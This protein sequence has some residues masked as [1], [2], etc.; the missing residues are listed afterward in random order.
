MLPTSSTWSRWRTRARCPPAFTS[1]AARTDH[2]PSTSCLPLEVRRERRCGDRPLPA[3][4]VMTNFDESVPRA[5][6][7]LTGD[8]PSRLTHRAHEA[9]QMRF[10]HRCNL[11]RSP[12]R[13]A[14]SPWW[15]LHSRCGVTCHPPLLV[16]RPL[17]I[18][19]SP[20]PAASGWLL[21]EMTSTFCGGSG[22]LYV[23]LLA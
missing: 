13:L 15:R 7:C 18:A 22:T 3:V 8:S 12:T 9:A 20:R 11:P 1:S 2:Q 10:R 14:S 19:V 4:S 17:S 16:H 21:C 6:L 5:I 23:R